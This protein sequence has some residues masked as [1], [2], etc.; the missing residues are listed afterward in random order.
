[1]SEYWA[2]VGEFLKMGLLLYAPF[3]LM[4]P[5]LWQWQ[6]KKAKNAEIRKE[7]QTLRELRQ[8]RSMLALAVQQDTQREEARRLA[9]DLRELNR[10]RERDEGA[11]FAAEG[12]Q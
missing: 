11:P 4:F 8:Q 9:T 7:E 10:D 3:V 12:S 6:Y 2:G 1:M 5:Y